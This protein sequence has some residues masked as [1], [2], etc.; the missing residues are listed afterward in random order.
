V[1]FGFFTAKTWE[2]TVESLRYCGFKGD[3]LA[4]LP[5]QQLD[6][7]VRITIE[8]SE[9]QGKMQA[10]VA[11][12]NAGY[13]GIKLA[14]PMDMNELRQFAARMKS[15]VKN[16]K[17]VEGKKAERT[18]ATPPASEPTPPPAAPDDDFPFA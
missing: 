7:E 5:A 18:Q 10:K 11:W 14:D 3:D 1:W 8:H 17:E 6:N 9:W 12:V 16:I 13:S 2:R 4:S 15:S